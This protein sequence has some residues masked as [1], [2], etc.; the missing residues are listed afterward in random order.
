MRIG[1]L[2]RAS[3]VAAS[4]IRFYEEERVLPPPRRTAN[5]YRAYPPSAVEAIRL[6]LQAQRLG[7]SL[8]EIR[9]AAPAGG[10]DALDCDQILRLLGR[11]SEMLRVQLVELTARLTEV[12][13]SIREFERRKKRSLRRRPARA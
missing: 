13:A 1:E 6:I 12:R 4:R 2:A 7:F 3:G 11:K 9:E 5:G 8:K 10:L